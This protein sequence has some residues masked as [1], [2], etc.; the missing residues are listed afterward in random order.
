M[1]TFLLNIVRN[2]PVLAG[3]TIVVSA[4]AERNN[5]A[6]THAFANIIWPRVKNFVPI[7][8][9]LSAK[10]LRQHPKILETFNSRDSWRNASRL[11]RRPPKNRSRRSAR[12]PGEP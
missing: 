6:L 2:F 11:Q 4:V 3:A 10:Y 5:I 1:R 8:G 12:V 7:A 9:S